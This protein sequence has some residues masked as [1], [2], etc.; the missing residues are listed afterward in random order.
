MAQK[1]SIKIKKCGV[2]KITSPSG[3][4]YIGSSKNI[5]YRWSEY[6]KLRCKVQTKLYR[7][8]TKY[9]P[10]N[11]SFEILE[12]CEIKDLYP[13][14]RAWGLFFNVLNKNG[15]NCKLPGYGEV[16]GLVS[17][18]TKVKIS[19]SNTGKK[20][21][22]ESIEKSRQSNLGRQAS[23]ETKQKMS[24]AQQGRKHTEETKLKMSK[25]K[26]DETKEKMSKGKLGNIYNMGR[27][28]TEEQKQKMREVWE[29]RKLN[30]LITKN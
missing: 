2:Y 17:E 11:H 10:E 27:K 6:K 19:V 12:E 9:G 1:I 30:K 8:I 29:T 18:D 3:R 4:I 23:D 15:L 13:L 21:S 28:C 5:Y 7:S 20:M 16:K 22:I 14:E 25:P 24:I 26:S